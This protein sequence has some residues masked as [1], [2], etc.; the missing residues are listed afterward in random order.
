MPNLFFKSLCAATVCCGLMSLVQSPSNLAFAFGKR[1]T[2]ATQGWEDMSYEGGSST[3]KFDQVHERGAL[4]EDGDT[5]RPKSKTSKFDHIQRGGAL[6]REEDLK[7]EEEDDREQA[8]EPA[9]EIPQKKVRKPQCP[10]ETDPSHCLKRAKKFTNEG[11]Y[12][13]ALVE[14]NQA[15]TLSPTFWEARYQ[16]AYIYQ[17][18]GR[19]KEAIQRYEDFLQRRPDHV[20]GHINLGSLFRKDGD[21]V[22]AE[23]HYKKAAELNHYSLDAHYNLS[24]VYIQQGKLEPALKELQICLKIKPDDAWVHNNLGVVYQRRHYLEEAE[25]EFLRALHLEPANKTFENNLDQVRTLLKKKP[26]KA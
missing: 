26:V 6:S 10:D 25:E 13:A 19:T 9:K 2:D 20:E 7:D 23:A 4:A 15:L 18:Q 1:E 16:G 3:A 22:A 24:N 17:L 14:I 11:N 21:F 5:E 12:I 8:T